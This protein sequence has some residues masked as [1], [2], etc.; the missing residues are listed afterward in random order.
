[1]NRVASNLSRICP[2]VLVYSYRCASTTPSA[3]GRLHVLYGSNPN[4]FI[5]YERDVSRDPRVKVPQKQGDTP[6]RFML[7]R[8]G[9]AYEVYP[10]IFLV[11]VWFVLF[12]YVTWFSFDK[13]EVWL[14]RSQKTAPWD[15]ERIRNNYWKK[16]TVIGDINGF[17]H[18][19]LEIMEKL[20]DKMLEAAKK[21]G[22]R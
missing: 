1:M 6:L 2:R 8:L 5:R 10:L 3:Q 17:T 14:D 20:Q 12:C 13:V 11:G 16:N 15:W 21:R 7:R 22:T 4:G 9:H 19:R 18:K